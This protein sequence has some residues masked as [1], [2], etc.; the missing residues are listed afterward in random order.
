[1]AW[2]YQSMRTPTALVLLLTLLAAGQASAPRPDDVSSPTAIV[3]A[4]YE[5]NS[6][7]PGKLDG[8]RLRS[9][10]APNARLMPFRRPKDGPAELMS[11]EPEQFV[12]RRLSAK[13]PFYEVEVSREMQEFGDTAHVWSTY[14]GR[15]EV[16]GKA[17][18]RGINS[19][20]LARYGGRWWV[21]SILWDTE[22]T[23]NPLPAQYLPR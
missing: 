22:R 9:L 5:A 8:V 17:F 4:L 16:A 21:V 13:E 23:G 15:R 19:F 18:V 7:E 11:L 20:Q 10:F 3:K 14:E 2:S 6:G 1:M 12:T